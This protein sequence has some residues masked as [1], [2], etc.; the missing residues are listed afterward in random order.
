M[1]DDNRT[2]IPEMVE[3][4]AKAAYERMVAVMLNG[5]PPI[6]PPAGLE[7]FASG[8]WSVQKETLREDWREAIGAAI[9]AL[10]VPTEAML[11]AGNASDGATE[12]WHEMIDAAL[13]E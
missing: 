6:D 2:K 10:R 9:A 11:K 8:D 3:R 4:A 13:A 5:S 1:A 12:T 7:A